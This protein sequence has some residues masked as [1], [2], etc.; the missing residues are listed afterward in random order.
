M[1]YTS[2]PKPPPSSEA[3]SPKSRSSISSDASH[4]SSSP[5]S[6]RGNKM[7]RVIPLSNDGEQIA[8]EPTFVFH[9]S[10]SF[11]QLWTFIMVSCYV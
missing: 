10:S 8:Y 5:L 9:Q 6:R 4:S 1:G 2:F 3:R 11:R 7:S